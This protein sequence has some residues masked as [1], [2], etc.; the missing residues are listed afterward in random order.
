MA[1]CRWNVSGV[2]AG[3]LDDQREDAMTCKSNRYS[4]LLG[5]RIYRSKYQDCQFSELRG[6]KVRLLMPKEIEEFRAH[7]E[8]VMSQQLPKKVPL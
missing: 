4:G 6:I 1:A 8:Q 2:D 7:M 3:R 5:S